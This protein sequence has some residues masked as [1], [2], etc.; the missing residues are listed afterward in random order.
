MAETGRETWGAAIADTIA[1]CHPG[2][3]GYE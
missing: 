2:L 1:N 3:D